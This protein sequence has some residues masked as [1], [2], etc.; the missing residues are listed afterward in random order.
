[1]TPRDA[2]APR[3]AH[4]RAGTPVG[5][6][7]LSPYDLLVRGDLGPWLA[8]QR[9]AILATT[10]RELLVVTAG[11]DGEV[12]LQALP[13]DATAGVVAAGPSTFYVVSDWRI[14]R[15]EDALAD[16]SGPRDGH[17]RH[18]LPQAARTTGFV[19]ALDL[20]LGREGRLL[21]SSTVA[22]CVA[23]PS[24][25]RSFT[26]GWKPPFLA[27]FGGEDRC[28]LTGLATAE[29]ALAYATAA[30]TVDAPGAWRDA[31]TAGGAVFDTQ[32]DEVVT[33]GLSVP[34]SPRI[35]GRR[36]FVANAGRGEL[37]AI[38]RS[39]GAVESVLRIDG[40]A[41]G[42]AVHERWAVVG[43]SKLPA[44][45]PYGASTVAAQPMR[46]SLTVV[47][48]TRGT[49][50]GDLEIRGGSGEIVALDLLVGTRR[51]RVA[52]EADTRERLVTIGTAAS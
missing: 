23:A 52:S 20:A 46:Q 7:V 11:E 50:V 2:D 32:A 18:Y 47:D 6:T 48:L 33:A 21:F 4:A 26:A 16:G 8:Q 31:V 13:M 9:V 17:D 28:H 19:G 38:D 27:A 40:F 35:A 12:A 45:S 43:G 3:D 34:H 30:G 36:L 22:N 5:L 10:G 24:R 42:L 41:R 39:S 15:F 49:V 44:G 14:W 1:M 37:L 51:P 25:R 29:G